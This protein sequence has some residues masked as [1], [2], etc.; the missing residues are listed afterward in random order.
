MRKNLRSISL[1]LLLLAIV[2]AT[3][4]GKIEKRITKVQTFPSTVCPGSDS[5]D[6]VIDYLPKSK[7]NAALIPNESGK[8]KPLGTS[9]LNS[10]KPL[11]VDGQDV[12]S[13]AIIKG[14]SG[15][16]A[17]ASCSISDGDDWFI[18]GSANITSRGY[19]EIVNSGLSAAQVDLK[20]YSKTA[21]RTVN[22]T[23]PANSVKYVKL[24]SL[25]PGEDSIAINAITRS[26][27]IS[28]FMLD[29]RGS[30]LR[31]LGGDFVAP[32]LAPAK[33]VVIPF[34]PTIKK[35]GQI[36][37]T[38][39]LVVPGSVDANLRATIFSSD[40][41]FAPRGIDGQ[42]VNGGTV[43]DID[44][45]PIVSDSSYALKIDSD[46]PLSASIF[47]TLGQDF[48]WSTAVQPLRSTTIRLGGFKPVM[49]FYGQ[50]IDLNLSWVDAN[51]KSSGKRITGSDT[52]S[53]ISK[54]GLNSITVENLN[55]ENYGS[56][57]ISNSSGDSVLPIVS[58]AHLESAA[59]PRSD[60]RAINRN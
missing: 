17:A 20:V 38:L 8:L 44:L 25:A 31:S 32:T 59:L 13:M 56:L 49:R 37:Q 30:G 41:S 2:I 22:K 4:F 33:S 28:V 24:D 1:F 29:K 34:V 60:V 5:G 39:R 40:G 46:V 3:S 14:S 21:P 10:S 16:L 53:F 52:V 35:G 19:L 23:I 54:I 36:T 55:G 51:G 18:G 9:I 48:I 42:S 45:N 11:L 6:V 57:K 12:T 58:G 27:R 50:S 43:K 26:G 15:W 47:T 7:I